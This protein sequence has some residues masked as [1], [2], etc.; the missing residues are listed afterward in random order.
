MKQQREEYESINDE[1]QEGFKSNNIDAINVGLY[2]VAN[3]LKVELPYSN[4][5]EFVDW[6]GTNPVIDL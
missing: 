6:S 1:I 4:T 5:K 2:K 3:F